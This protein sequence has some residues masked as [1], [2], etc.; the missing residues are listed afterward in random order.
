MRQI[1]VEFYNLLTIF[2]NIVWRID[3]DFRIIRMGRGTFEIRDDGNLKYRI[4]EKLASVFLD[5]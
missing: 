2:R 1:Y 5:E 3:Y 4:A